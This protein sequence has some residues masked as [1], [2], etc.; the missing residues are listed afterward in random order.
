[1]FGLVCQTDAVPDDAADCAVVDSLLATAS[2]GS[3]RP[4]TTLSEE[5]FFTV[6]TPIHKSIDNELVW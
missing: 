2:G 3:T 6:R 5:H 4:R 1:M